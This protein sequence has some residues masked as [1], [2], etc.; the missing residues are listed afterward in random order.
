M[1]SGGSF[2]GIRL[3]AMT[4]VFALAVG[5]VPSLSGPDLAS[6]ADLPEQHQG[7]AADRGHEVS[8]EETSERAGLAD[9]SHNAEP[10]NNGL[11]PDERRKQPVVD[12]SGQAETGVEVQ[13]T[14]PERTRRASSPSPDATPEKRGPRHAVFDNGDGTK[15]LRQYQHRRN[16]RAE[17]GK[18]K[19][20]DS[21][22]V[23]G[24]GGGW[25][26]KA[27][28]ETKRF[29]PSANASEVARF[30]VDTDKSVGFGVAGAR[31]VQGD[32]SGQSITYPDVRAGAD[33]EMRATATGIKE[34]IVLESPDAPTEWKFPL[35]LEGLTARMTD[36][37]GVEL[38]DGDGAVEAV[39]PPGYMEDSAVDERS[40]DGA[41]SHD[42]NYELSGEPGSQVLHVSADQEWLN[43]PARE[44]PVSVDPTVV[45]KDSNGSTYVMSPYTDDYSGEP[46]LKVGTYNGG[47][48]V[49]AAFLKFDKVSTD[50]SGMYVLGARLNVYNT[51]SY[52][53]DPR[54]VWVRTVTE[55]WSV[56]GNKSWPGP[57]A[58]ERLARKDFAH[59][60]DGCG[61]RW[62][63]ID[64]GTAGR[65]LVHGWAR[66]GPN[67]GLRLGS[68]YTDS[69]G[70]K[71]FASAASANPPALDVTYTPYW[72]LYRNLQMTD[73]VT[74]TDDGTMQ[75][76]VTNDGKDTWTPDNGYELGY[77]IWD[78]DG[79]ELPYQ[80]WA[81][82]TKMSKRVEPGQSATV[83]ARVKSLPPGDYTIRWDMA[84][85]GETRF[86]WND[87]PMSAKVKL[88]IPNQVPEVESMSPPSDYDAGSLTPTL[89]LEGQ[90]RDD[91]PGD[92]LQYEFRICDEGG[93]NCTSSGWLDE[94][95]WSVPDDTLSWGKTYSWQGRITDGKDSSRWTRAAYLNTRVA[96]PAITSRLASA[97]DADSDVD[98]GV[99]NY[100]RAD[101]DA[102]V[103]TAGPALSVRRTY[104]SLDPRGD[105][106]FGSGWTTRW[107]MRVV[108][109]DDGSGNVV[110]TYPDGRQVRY[111]Q[112]PDGSYAT[113]AGESA[114]LV[115][116][117][118]DWVLR[119]KGGTTYRFDESGHLTRITDAAGRN[120]K[121]DYDDSGQLSRATDEASGRYLDFSFSDG[122]V[123]GVTT[124]PEPAATWSYEYTGDR[125]VSACD[126][127]GVCTSYG[128]EQGGQYRP[129]TLDANPH[130]YWR[131]AETSGE[132]ADSEQPGYW[133]DR[134]ADY[135]DVELGR[136]G[137]L[138]D[139]PSR[140]A[141]FNGTSSYVKL[142]GN[143]VHDS[144][145]RAVELWFNTSADQGGVLFSQGNF[146]PGD[147][148]GETGSTP[149]LYVGTDGK[150]YG[151]FWNGNVAGISTS[152]AVND[153]Q[154]HHVVLS[155]EPDSQTLYLDGQKVGSQDGRVR[156]YYG[157]AY[158]GAGVVT[159]LDWPARPEHSWGNFSGR[160]GEV[161]VYQRP[162]GP[163]TVAEHHA[164]RAATD[165]LTSVTES[166][167]VRKASISYDN[168]T[169]RV[170]EYTDANGG[171]HQIGMPRVEGDGHRFGESVT[172]S[173][174]DAY[175]RL[176]E[177]SGDRAGGKPELRRASYYA[178]VGT[179]V[180]GPLP[181]SSARQ[182][183]GEKAKVTLP[184][185][186]ASANNEMSVELWFK[187]SSDEG[188]VL[189]S[190]GNFR[191]GDEISETGSTPAL[192]VG[193]DGKLYGHFWNGEV[194]GIA[195][196]DA[197]NDGQWHHVT[198][199]AT[200]NQQTLY[201]D[202][203]KVGSESGQIQTRYLHAYVGAGVVTTAGWPERP[204]DAWGHFDGAISQVALYQRPVSADEVSTHYTA[205]GGRA[206]YRNAVR[207]SGPLA[208]W[209]LEE[210]SSA[211]RAESDPALSHGAYHN[212]GRDAVPAMNSAG[213]A[214]F[215][216][217]D[218]Y[219][220]LPDGLV[221][222]RTRTSLE[223]WF[224]TS[225]D[226]GGV[227]LS[228]ADSLPGDTETP[229]AMP[230]L[231]VG[232]DG[233]LYGH[234]WNDKA[235]GIVTDE[236]V[237]DGEWHHVALTANLDWQWLYL[238]G[239]EVGR[240]K[241]EI[242]SR[243]R[244]HFV[245]TGKMTQGPDW[246]ARPDEAWSYF[247]GSIGE[248]AMYR[249][250]LS[251]A[252]VSKHYA[253]SVAAHS[254]EVTDP[255]GNVTRRTYDPTRGGRLVSR[256]DPGGGT[257]VYSYD[258]GGFVRT[259]SDEN[260][261]VTRLRHDERGNRLSRTR[262]RTDNTEACYTAYWSYFLN[263]DDPLDPRNDKVTEFRDA[264]S[265]GQGDGRYL[266]T[267]SYTSTGQ[268]TEIKSPD[269]SNG[270]Q[271]SQTRTYTDGT[272][273]APDGGTQPPGLLATMTDPKGGETSYAYNSAGDRVS[274]TDPVGLVTEYS[275]D[276][277]GRV[278]QESVV[279]ASSGQTTRTTFDYDA[280]GRILSETDPQV[281]NPITNE[282]H[283][284]RLVNNYNAHGRLAS[285]TVE[286]IA[287]DDPSR[288][289]KYGYDEL[290][291]RNTVTDP[292]GGTEQV[293]HDQFGE[294]QR[295]TT[296]AGTVFSYTY[297]AD[298][299]RLATTTVHDFT[300]DGGTGRDVV[301][302]S[303]AYDPA[304][305]LAEVTD[306]MGNTTAYTYY[307]DGLKATE[308]LVGYEDPD[309]GETRDLLLSSY[310]YTG[311]GKVTKETRGQGRYS[312]VTEYDPGGRAYRTTDYDGDEELR[313]TRTRFTE[314]G[315]P[316]RV[317][318]RNAAGDQ[319]TRTDYAYD[320]VGETIRETV[321]PGGGETL[322][323]TTQRDERGLLVSVTDPR[324]TA[325][326]ADPAKFTTE[327]E[328]D[329]LGRE[330][331][332]TGPAVQVESNGEQP[333]TSRP[334][335]KTGYNTFGDV[336][337]EQDP[338]GDVTRHGFDRAGRQTS[339]T[340]P[341][342]TPPGA[343]QPIT[344]TTTA[345]YDAAGRVSSGTDEAGHTTKFEY[346]ELGNQR[347]KIDPSLSGDGSGGVTTATY[348][349]TGWQLS[350]RDAN[351]ARTHAT[352]DQ[353]GR[354]I[355]E[356]VVER[357]PSPE[358]ALTTRFRYDD[359]GN[360]ATRTDPAGRATTLVHNDQ[361]DPVS[362]TDAAGTEIT[363]QYDA[364]GR[365]VEVSD[366]ATATTRFSYDNA[367]R[368]TS[369]SDVASDGE[370]LATRSFG[371]DRA[372][373]RTEST[374]ELGHTT[375][376][377]FDA[378]DQLRAVTRPVDGDTSITR[379][380]G[381]DAAGNLTRATDGNGNAT[382]FTA[383]SWGLTESTIEP[384]TEQTPDQAD[385]TYTVAYTE[386]GNVSSLSKPGGVTINNS[387]DPMG[388]LV[389]QTATGAKAATADREFTYDE[390]G[391]MLS[392]SA[393]A[394]ENTYEY[395]D[396]GNV[397]AAHGPSGSTEF[398]WDDGGQLTKAVT[399]AGTVE[400]G[401]DAAGR[402]ASAADPVSG[403]T[404]S[405]GYDEAGRI[406]TVDYGDG[407]SRSYEYDESGRLL[408]D[409]VT[410]GG[411]SQ[412]GSIS[413]GYGPAGRLASKTTTGVAGAAENTYTYDR[414]GRLGS[415]SDGSSTTNYEW[416]AAGNL[417]QRG[418]E[419]ATYNA[420]N[421]LLS[422]GDT[423]YSYTARGTLS[424]RTQ[425]GQTTDVV[426]N[427]FDELV[428]DGGTSYSYDALNRLVN[429]GE[430]QLSYVGKSLD[431]A[432]DGSSSYTYTPGG[433]SLGAA[434]GIAWSDRH[435]DL[436]GVLDPAE[437]SLAGSR[438][439]GP[440]GAVTASGGA[441]PDVGFQG[442]FTD[443]G[444]GN[445]S[446]GS[447]W[448][449]PGTGA[450]ASRDT[451]ALDPRD[452]GNAN[453]YAYA[454]G[455]PM[456]RV[457]PRGYF[458]SEIW[459]GVVEVTKEMSGY[460]DFMGCVGGSWGSC[461]SFAVG[462][463]PVGKI[464]KGVKAGYR[465]ARKVVG[466][467][468]AGSVGQSSRRHV[469]AGKT[470]KP[471]P[472]RSSKPSSKRPSKR[473]FRR[474]SG[475][476]VRSGARSVVRRSAVVGVRGVVSS[477]GSAAS[478]A[479]AAAAAREAARVAARRA[480][481]R[482][483]ALTPAAAPP[484]S[485]AISPGVQ[486]HLDRLRNKPTIDLG[487]V[488]G[489]AASGKT[490]P[491]FV[492][493]SVGGAA[494]VSVSAGPARS[495]SSVPSVGPPSPDA[496]LP[497]AVPKRGTGS[498]CRPNSFVPGTEVELADGSRRPIEEVQRGDRVLATDP[499]SGE[500]GPREVTEVITGSGRKSL[501]TLT[502]DTDGPAGD[503]TGSVTA[504]E[505]HPFWIDDEGRWLA[506]SQIEP[507]DLLRT[508]QGERVRV[509]D[510]DTT[511]RTQRVHNLTVDG[512][513]TYHVEA[514]TLALLVHNTGPGCEP[515]AGIPSSVAE[516]AP[517][518]EH[519][520]LQKK[521]GKAATREL[522]DGRIRYYRKLRPANNPGEMAGMR[523]VR[524]WDPVRDIKRTWMETV[525]HSGK[526][527]QVRPD[528][529]GR[530][531]PHYRFDELGRLVGS[532]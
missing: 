209:G 105:L 216:G 474:D 181:D 49:A 214:Q 479:A 204:S 22:L 189:F 267:Y 213:A 510:T 482:R 44:Y 417:V 413:Y 428:S 359:L 275:H 316:S 99:G 190:Q 57:A 122:H 152:D 345:S 6:S 410:D 211:L 14:E 349:A 163:T 286:D 380:Y 81:A 73:T 442:Q 274:E 481:V 259:I 141:E 162:L 362:M 252:E 132:T 453:R 486:R 249:R 31:D 508:A 125:L 294:V 113:P 228:N 115:T 331:S 516:G 112:N 108:P 253:A 255:A 160:I 226:G 295:R 351:G 197:V 517:L 368:V 456:A 54:P 247:D 454:G 515:G 304:G 289:T 77:R 87:V 23:R 323:T 72:A 412:I 177:S 440:F 514:D 337:A 452:G 58:G 405:Y 172:R 292:E 339:T 293:T 130:G 215:N 492:P 5:S 403:T 327:Y 60:R 431:I 478:R 242:D 4:V 507:G 399:D 168:A 268:I 188:G 175:W 194:S 38:A 47:D 350:V 439:F 91:W 530:E 123:T 287:G 434:G 173:G 386:R 176:D 19:K 352:Y 97:S 119:A 269:A 374:N 308:H 147:E 408:G 26:S 13:E 338:N 497:S 475:R 458:W 415:W 34:T 322:V 436:V 356:S 232:T 128:Y 382:V 129:T 191:P 56:S 203:A 192:Y 51:Y 389:S 201:L 270:A 395:D 409:T 527:R 222:N 354:K 52:S 430:R 151:H 20:I 509:V 110:V 161:A 238:D 139:V 282:P 69:Y 393:P 92:G 401:Y 302:E 86:S 416:D 483:A 499:E 210:K 300:G 68:S 140:A 423:S 506:A 1:Q 279:A 445:V 127:T 157:N 79:N 155:S 381:Y 88:T 477:G 493:D 199:S 45:R 103:S 318:E 379:S 296:K 332:A 373:N 236:T 256:T 136:E 369:E 438:S 471:S 290:G 37:G 414:A 396:R 195:S 8:A 218:S 303:R 422:F 16:Y 317:I 66:G 446:M 120:Q 144:E 407:A 489:R 468:K 93:D 74:S 299:H 39:I 15:T 357:E 470:A 411:G 182:F 126:P 262:C 281:T 82:F 385:R 178:K 28:S 21:T 118:G 102:E 59:G 310:A 185:H 501:V 10:A 198:L 358:Q 311:H 43:D 528:F 391:R 283:Q 55:P 496:G 512:I 100:T 17:D 207:D 525:D 36:H 241:G 98:P 179:R 40:G 319:L 529:D 390:T 240:Q 400:Y 448:Y 7:S 170:T 96:Q 264:R 343:D 336:V 180:S 467:G 137:P 135:S 2:R 200:R 355:T 165:R 224:K 167:D 301:L 429:A 433:D 67:F 321:H 142:H 171:T 154:W 367:G 441:Q 309:T 260:G 314:L 107:D 64:L 205:R 476:V 186:A 329:R 341:S 234:L 244:H 206:D 502:V 312:T 133:S 111:G 443:A 437:G 106:V 18:W 419:S 335:S 250:A 276:G 153:G 333:S 254:V 221:Q 463:T 217:A 363:A 114:T 277:L 131:L 243:R 465:G 251:S 340:R 263:E 138:T 353:L 174:P 245:G 469:G 320:A 464:A 376:R 248:V 371:Y 78:G 134:T 76:T 495:G 9:A 149:V 261:H 484:K 196:S 280:A 48:N 425:G 418:D 89:L 183:D 94:G 305:R 219:V 124:G 223:L 435:T 273:S 271:L 491:R 459:D 346:D 266:T 449:R 32:A 30:N 101:T 472:K 466:G 117:S 150:L 169:S 394:G 90:D 246:P 432:S 361:G 523:K 84:K 420:R 159:T 231:Y 24:N 365:P 461:G 532:W 334:V 522:P 427:A 104:N 229:G 377:E 11:G 513:H 402:L 85:R 50:L 487:V 450:F 480:R 164:A 387:Y 121:L 498:V 63:N 383:N 65:D 202:G 511:Q 35:E 424:S 347:K 3:F 313:S 158:I 500:Q 265:A 524:E 485:V 406:S 278:T 370:V 225:S 75:V 520:R 166:G 348:T 460:N 284:R 46:N 366:P 504:T 288:T 239:N 473:S 109:D 148:I 447:R 378:Y 375:T 488:G 184:M 83:D 272:E 455:D 388:N 220:R 237:N 307:N 25:K 326:G 505:G 518:K 235:K 70:W 33:L 298:G 42:V 372:G 398:S 315:N 426:F 344:A 444:S 187:T 421:Q 27:D 531:G 360:L 384:A 146:R 519:R 80:E 462:F 95:V 257:T 297:T 392:A 227:L 143:P 324:G 116:D 71:K 325:E 451:A 193:T 41:V 404:A 53:C 490:A 364:A 285:S 212:V 503:E 306:A 526:I 208:L 330:I 342:Y 145:Y 29:A 328:Y 457:D 494:R 291:R 230:I 521:Y 397:V 258:A 61:S 156:D 62:V 233:R 12:G